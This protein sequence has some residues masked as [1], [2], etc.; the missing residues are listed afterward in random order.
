M[1]SDVMFIVIYPLA[2]SPSV[3]YASLFAPPRILALA[4]SAALMVPAAPAQP[5]YLNQLTSLGVMYA[6]RPIRKGKK[7]VL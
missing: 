7:I 4:A 1:N 6:V 5:L 3:L 2:R